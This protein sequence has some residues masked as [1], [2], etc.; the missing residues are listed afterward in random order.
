MPDHRD[1]ML[2]TLNCGSTSLKFSLFTIEDPSAASSSYPVRPEYSGELV[3][4]GES[5]EMTICDAD[6]KELLR[7]FVFAV[8]HEHAMREMLRWFDERLGASARIALVGHR[9][10]HGGRR[11]H[12]PT[13]ITPGVMQY[14]KTL[15]PLAPNH[16]PVNLLGIELLEQLEPG[17]P[18][19]ACFD[20]AFHVTR[21]EVEQR[22][23]LPQNELLESVYSYGFHGLS[24]EYI[25]EVMPDYL[26][27]LSAGRV[28]VAH[29][30]HGV[31]LCAMK[32]R[33][34][35]ATTMTFTP[36]DGVPS[37]TRCGSID[38]G[39]VLY[40]QKRGMKNKQISDLLYFKSGLLGVSGISDH[41]TV[42]LNHSA[43]EA[44]LAVDMFVH[45]TIKAIGSLAAAMHGIDAVIFTGGMGERSDV[46][47]ARICK[48]IKWMGVRLDPAA[49]AEHA[50]RIT[51]KKSPLSAWVIPTDEERMIAHHA[52]MVQKQQPDFDN[53]RV[54]RYSDRNTPTD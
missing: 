41:I 12:E 48:G 16:Q 37:A 28:V 32:N 9:I 7:R 25:A 36:L 40:L 17:I 4:I 33:R 53:G 1:R 47:R 46:I 42:L 18:Q 44:K 2:L 13:L 39:V 38:P 27:N 50:T 19:V 21:P 15:I 29:L 49:N 11:F 6:G 51:K 14:L 30:G 43:P 34:S 31:S 8:D 35:V 3:N 5:G 24:Y 26:G 45:H 23:A 20:T 54:E 22:F 10:V 52:C